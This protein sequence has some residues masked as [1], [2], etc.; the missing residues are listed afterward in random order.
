MGKLNF[1]KNIVVTASPRPARAPNGLSIPSSGGFISRKIV[2]SPFLSS[3]L[4]GQ[5]VGQLYTLTSDQASLVSSVLH[6][7][8]LT[9]LLVVLESE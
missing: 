5:L 7:F 1:S 4:K 2:E 6:V 9:V 3:Y 8:L